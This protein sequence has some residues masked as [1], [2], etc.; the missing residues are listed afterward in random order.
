MWPLVSFPRS[1]G[2]HIP[3]SGVAISYLSRRAYSV[4]RY[5]PALVVDDK[6]MDQ[7]V[8]HNYNLHWA[9]HFYTCMPVSAFLTWCQ[10]H[11]MLVGKVKVKVAFPRQ[12]LIWFGSN[13]VSVLN[14][15]LT[16]RTQYVSWVRRVFKR[17][18]WGV[19]SVQPTV[20]KKTLCAGFSPDT[21]WREIFG[22]FH[23]D[24]LHWASRFLSSFDDLDALVWSQE[25]LKT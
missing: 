24:D 1:A 12:A 17:N 15:R 7:T 14:A 6:G 20:I 10:G 13:F 4:R 5:F 22:T 2:S 9:L 18:N 3:S 21:Y 23:G 25:S 8:V 16:S 19:S 11:N